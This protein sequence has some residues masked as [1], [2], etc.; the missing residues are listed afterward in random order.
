MLG[1]P[2]LHWN[3]SSLLRD[4]SDI[5]RFQKGTCSLGLTNI[6]FICAIL[7]LKQIYWLFIYVS[8]YIFSLLN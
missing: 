2:K 1:R 4:S 5:Q 7:D 8:K 3:Y 6:K